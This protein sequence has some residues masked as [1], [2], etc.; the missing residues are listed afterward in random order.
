MISVWWAQG[1]QLVILCVQVAKPGR[2][3]GRRRRL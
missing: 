2:H 1:L 3:S